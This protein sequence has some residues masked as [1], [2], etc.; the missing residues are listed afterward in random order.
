MAQFPGHSSAIVTG[1]RCGFMAVLRGLKSRVISR[2]YRVFNYW[3]SVPNCLSSS[4]WSNF[5]HNFWCFDLNSGCSEIFFWFDKTNHI[6]F[7]QSWYDQSFQGRVMRGWC[8]NLSSCCKLFFRLENYYFSKFGKFHVEYSIM[9]LL[10]EWVSL[11][12]LLKV[13]TWDALVGTKL[14]KWKGFRFSWVNAFVLVC[15]KVATR[16]TRLLSFAH[17]LLC[18]YGV[19]IQFMEVASFASLV[20]EFGSQGGMSGGLLQDF[21]SVLTCFVAGYFPFDPGGLYVLCL[22]AVLGSCRWVVQLLL[23]CLRNHSCAPLLSHLDRRVN[24]WA[25]LMCEVIKLFQGLSKQLPNFFSAGK[26][27][28]SLVLSLNNLCLYVI[29]TGAS[30]T[31]CHEHVDYD[32]VLVVL[33]H[34]IV[35]FYRNESLHMMLVDFVTTSDG[36]CCPFL[37]CISVRKSVSLIFLAA[38]ARGFFASFEDFVAIILHVI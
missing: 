33:L 9:W 34:L 15:L 23:I 7:K 29:A 21:S 28:I 6:N 4:M 27:V 37:S 14:C 17:F 25:C 36:M 19:K 2:V 1:F 8:W 22:E 11:E 16:G 24:R 20:C 10:Q 31:Y 5:L 38:W 13:G 18:P 12:I 35:R 32:L 30:S 26:L 3:R